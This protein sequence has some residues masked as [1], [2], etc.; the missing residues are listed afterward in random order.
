MS[1]VLDVTQNN[2]G[3]RIQP[4]STFCPETKVIVTGN[5]WTTYKHYYQLL[6]PFMFTVVYKEL[7]RQTNIHSCNNFTYNVANWSGD[8]G[9]KVSCNFLGKV[10]DFVENLGGNN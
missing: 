6:Y 8:Y 9:C 3:A 5:N 10:L 1:L 4:W 2:Y 7:S